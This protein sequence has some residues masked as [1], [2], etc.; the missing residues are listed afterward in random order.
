MCDG[1]ILL[2]RLQHDWN[3]PESRGIIMIILILIS[4]SIGLVCITMIHLQYHPEFAMISHR[5]SNRIRLDTL[6][7]GTVSTCSIWL[8]SKAV[9]GNSMTGLLTC[10]LS[11]HIMLGNSSSPKSGMSRAFSCQGFHTTVSGKL[12]FCTRIFLPETTFVM[13]CSGCV[14]W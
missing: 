7:I 11:T 14:F 2:I 3:S 1:N 10:P 6:L 12:Y 5:R 8:A 4:L 13:I 9:P